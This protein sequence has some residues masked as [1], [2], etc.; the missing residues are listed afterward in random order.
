MV[1]GVF[2]ELIEKDTT[3][4]QQLTLTF[5]IEFLLFHQVSITLHFYFH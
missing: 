2:D 3:C 1:Q 4:R 5:I